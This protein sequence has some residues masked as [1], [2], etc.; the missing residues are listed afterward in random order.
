MAP[1]R[2]PSPDEALGLHHSR[3]WSLLILVLMAVHTYF[4]WTWNT[5]PELLWGCNV[6]SLVII[7]GLWLRSA[8]LVGLGFLWHICVGEPGWLYGV[9]ASGH[10]NAISV[11][12]HSIPTV[13]AFLYLR[14]TGLP[15]SAPYLATLLF[16]ALVPLSHYLTPAPM[17]VNLA[18]QRL[19]FLQQA[20][21]G[22]WPY[23]FAFTG[24][25]LLLLL[26]GDALFAGWLG[27]WPA[28]R[29]RPRA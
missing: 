21:P 23:R 4:K 20:F 1:R 8:H 13:A 24:A 10:T 19:P 16:V 28:P 18:H 26:L 2:D 5:L 27:R 14:R 3:T 15:R 17:N 22:N 7:L 6:A 11:L 12:V 9:W 29:R 25:M